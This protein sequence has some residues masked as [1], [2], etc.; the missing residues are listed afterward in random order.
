MGTVQFTIITD[1]AAQEYVAQ[2]AERYV[3]AEQV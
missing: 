2:G 3:R 1:L